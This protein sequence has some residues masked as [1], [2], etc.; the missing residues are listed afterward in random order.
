MVLY[1]KDTPTIVILIE[2]G[3][4]MR[5]RQKMKRTKKISFFMLTAVVLLV[6]CSTGVHN[7][8]EM[9]EKYS[10]IDSVVE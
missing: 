5:G 9:T 3:D 10:C 8:S 6:G 1:V 4:K 2:V 7:D